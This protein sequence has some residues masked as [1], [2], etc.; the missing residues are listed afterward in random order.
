[1][2]TWDD[3]LFR[4]LEGELGQP[5]KSEQIHWR[6]QSV[7]KNKPDTAQ[8]LAYIDARDVMERLDGVM[9]IA[10]WQTNYSHAGEKTICNLGLRIDNEWIWRADGAG[11]TDVE[12]EKG[13]ISSAFKR[14]AVH[15]GIGRYLYSLGRT[16]AKID[17]QRKFI[18]DDEYTQLNR[19]HDELAAKVGE[20]SP[21][22]R[23]TFRFLYQTI[24]TFVEGREHAEQFWA[25]NKGMIN[26]L[27]K[28][29]RER[30]IGLLKQK[31]G[32]NA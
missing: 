1:M 20:A 30:V 32:D 6:V 14:A 31:A 25:E 3:E 22:E 7:L 26:Q 29:S 12:G 17:P 10:N 21:A 16:Y 18:L 9:G 19:K 11:N 15:W 24:N 5:F 4:E 2:D 13:A 23:S 28:V 27:R 8:V